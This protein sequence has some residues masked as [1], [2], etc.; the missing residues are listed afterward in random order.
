ML[1]YVIGVNL[2][3]Q[4]HKSKTGSQIIPTTHLKIF[5]KQSRQI[6]HTFDQT[7]ESNSKLKE[8]EIMPAR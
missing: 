2:I 3:E 4:C 5:P 7:A 8:P 1:S 6:A